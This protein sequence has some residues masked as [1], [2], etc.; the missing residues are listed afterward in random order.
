MQAIPRIAKNTA[1]RRQSNIVSELSAALKVG[2]FDHELVCP[3]EYSN[4]V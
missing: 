4:I 2:W 3:A 1:E